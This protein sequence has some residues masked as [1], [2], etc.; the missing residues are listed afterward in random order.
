MSA[1]PFAF[2][3]SIVY[4]TS[5]VQ[6]HQQT[7]EF[8]PALTAADEFD[9]FELRAVRNFRLV[10]IAFAD[11]GLVEFHGYPVALDLQ[12]LE[13]C[14]NRLIAGN[15]ARFS[16]HGNADKVRL[17]LQVETGFDSPFAF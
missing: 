16:I 11:D 9:Y 6:N 13:Q 14:R 4:A 12:V 10:P 8:S 15:L 7:R 3:P 1:Q 2:S 5:G 17:H